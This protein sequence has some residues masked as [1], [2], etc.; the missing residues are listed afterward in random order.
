MGY[1]PAACAKAMGPIW[2]SWTGQVERSW[3]MA[4]SRRARMSYLV[5][6]RSALA[7]A[8]NMMGLRWNVLVTSE[9][10]SWKEH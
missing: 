9:S 3:E 4:H 2:S 8:S 10:V 5:E 1:G 7:R 6:I